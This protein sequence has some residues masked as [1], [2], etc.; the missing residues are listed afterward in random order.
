MKNN[1]IGILIDR[2]N[3][4]G[5]EKI[6][7]EEVRAL[8]SLGKDA[9]LVVLKKRG[10][11]ENAFLD[12]RKGLPIIYLDDRL[13]FFLKFSFKFPIFHF[14]SFFHLSYPILLSFFL[15]KNEF[16][17]LIVHGTYTAFSAILFKKIKGIRFSVFIWDPIGYILN[18]VYFRQ[19]SF[20]RKF[21]IKIAKVLDKWI[22]DNSDVILVGGDAHNKY[23]RVLNSKVII[24]TVF[25]SVYP[26][27]K[28]SKKKEDYILMV[29]AWK[30]GKN[31]EYI[32]S[33][34]E[35]IPQ[36][37]IKM[38]GKWLDDS[39]RKEF[40]TQLKERGFAKNISVIGE[41]NEKD[42]SRYYSK[43]ILLLQTNDDRGFGMPALEAAAHGTTFI[44]PKGQGVCNLFSNKVDGFF[45]K[46]KDTE[47]IVNYLKL[48]T[49][50]SKLAIKMGEHAWKMVI[51]NYTWKN[52]A[53]RL[54]KVIDAYA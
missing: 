11:V 4:G 23:I 12:L 25:P 19:L 7:L 17:Y 37:K 14:F 52:H 45:T 8:R 13:P 43:S 54:I 49:K 51:N 18:R 50:N 27:K 47:S 28:I 22:I 24:K 53:K 2:M 33:L 40:E 20:F 10:V 34:V 38:L 30:R 9:Y 48:L 44:I 39:Y 1:K 3:V 35:R 32:F 41:V 21:F 36:L 46:E 16:D 5:V 26:L 15:K 6:A 29:T 42:L 31:P